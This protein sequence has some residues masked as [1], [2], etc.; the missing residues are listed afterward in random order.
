MRE[1][2]SKNI[3]R[4]QTIDKYSQ[5][6]AAVAKTA[7]CT[8]IGTT[9]VLSVSEA[10]KP[11]EEH[12]DRCLR[13]GMSTDQLGSRYAGAGHKLLKTGD[14]LAGAELTASSETF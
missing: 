9:N 1:K 10:D 2:V 7:A 4:T 11:I 8:W 3:S 6:Q 13:Q 12:G 5:R 14:R